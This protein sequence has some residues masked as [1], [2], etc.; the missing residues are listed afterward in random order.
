M[1]VD[2][3]KLLVMRRSENIAN[4]CF[5]PDEIIIQGRGRGRNMAGTYMIYLSMHSVVKELVQKISDTYIYNN[6]IVLVHDINIVHSITS[7]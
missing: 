2:G 4:T 7:S 1:R 6:D 3:C 5:V